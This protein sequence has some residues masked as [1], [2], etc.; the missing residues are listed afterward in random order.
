MLLMPTTDG[1]IQWELHLKVIPNRPSPTQ[2]KASLFRASNFKTTGYINWINLYLNSQ[3]HWDNP[4]L[5]ALSLLALRH[6]VCGLPVSA[7]A[8][9]EY[10][11]SGD[12]RLAVWSRFIWQWCFVGLRQYSWLCL[13]FGGH[14]GLSHG[15]ILRLFSIILRA[16]LGFLCLGIERLYIHH[17][18][19][20]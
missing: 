20:Q 11:P 17:Y 13:Y 2:S 5:S 9:K 8:R 16:D 18:K 19:Q 12:F 15:V 3:W 6:T 10:S 14:G 7:Y 1:F 4:L